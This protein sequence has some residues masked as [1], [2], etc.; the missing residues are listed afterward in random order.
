MTL[1]VR[2]EGK[3]HRVELASDAVV[4]DLQAKLVE[5]TGIR[6]ER[7]VLKNGFPPK[8]MQ[9]ASASDA[10]QAVG[11]KHREAL[12]VEEGATGSVADAAGAPAGGD[13]GDSAPGLPDRQRHPRQV[14]AGLVELGTGSVERHVIPADNSCLFASI[15]Y[16]LRRHVVA[17]Y[18]LVPADLRKV[19]VEE[20]RRDPGT[21]DMLTLAECEKPSLEY[22][23]WIAK[24]D[25][26]GGFLEL[27]ILS[28]YFQVQIVAVDIVSTRMERFPHDDKVYPFRIFV[29]FDG[30]H[31]DACKRGEA[32][33]FRTESEEVSSEAMVVAIDLNSK[34]QFTDTGN[35]TLQCQH[36]WTKLRGEKEA[37]E[38][39]KE[40]GHFNFQECK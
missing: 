9:I 11:I 7:Q 32:T 21:Y 28:E 40:T 14:P 15:L 2:H 6:P 35:F 19:V 30:I 36:C 10:C 33:I 34:K 25:S 3:S 20:I 38:H 4:R 26:W 27:S 31:Y 12:I 18:E 23:D 24:D 22:C 29:F 1:Q 39:G 8:A 5:L 17:P 16:G 37:Q 13:A